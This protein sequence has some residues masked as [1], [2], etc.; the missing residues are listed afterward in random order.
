MRYRLTVRL[1]EADVG[2]RVVIRWR[3]P[4]S[5]GGDEMADVIGTL[6]A[7]DDVAFT[8]RTASGD[9]VVISR[10]RALA[11]KPVPPPPSR[12]A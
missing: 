8:V 7:A 4:S 3:R 12:R 6:E 2:R 9:A 10:D 1:G 11:G 5:G